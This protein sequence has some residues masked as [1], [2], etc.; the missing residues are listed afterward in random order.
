MRWN[1]AV[2]GLALM[3][4]GASAQTVYIGTQSEALWAARLDPQT[5]A[6]SAP[7]KAAMVAR[8][9]WLALDAPHARLFAVSETGTDRTEQGGVVS[10]AIE[11]GAA[12][13]VAWCRGQRADVSVA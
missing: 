8:P 12:R 13:P 4:S 2:L 10:Y 9:T 11:H 6:L 1:E 7:E 3:A 5:G